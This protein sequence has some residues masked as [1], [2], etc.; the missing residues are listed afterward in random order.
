MGL[1]RLCLLPAVGTGVSSHAGRS[2]EL[3]LH[4]ESKGFVYPKIKP[5]DL[6]VGQRGGICDGVQPGGLPG[7]GGLSGKTLL[8]FY[9]CLCLFLCLMASFALVLSICLPL[10][11]SLTLPD[12]KLCPIPMTPNGHLDPSLPLGG[13]LGPA[14]SAASAPRLSLQPDP[15]L[16]ALGSRKSSVMSLGRM[17]YDQ[18]SLVSPCGVL[19]MAASCQVCVEGP[20]EEVSACPASDWYL[21]L[22]NQTVQPEPGGEHVYC[23]PGCPGT[24]QEL[25]TRNE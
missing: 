17:S 10:S 15:M 23:I 16:M 5:R 12:P 7:G 18:R 22:G 3:A 21:G 20:W 9:F 2:W 8:H 13:R 14:G 4:V 6:Q 11:I 1:D 25:A 19:W 24:E